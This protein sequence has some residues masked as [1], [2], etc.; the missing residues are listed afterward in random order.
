GPGMAAC[1][2]CEAEGLEIVSFSPATQE[3]INELLPP[4]ALRTNPVD[5]GPAWY[6]ASA[7]A[8]I[9]RAV[10][11]DDKVDAVLLLMMFASANREAVPG[12]A[13]LLS[14][15][16]P[17]KPLVTC[18]ISPPG[19]WDEQVEHMEDAGVLV[20]MSTPERAAK[21]LASLWHYRKILNGE[22]YER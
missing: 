13:R 12:I 16:K 1:D 19:I 8:G 5:M 18:L 6:N 14:A 7:T 2:I 21:A 20:N 4:L 3:V 17:P 10:I 15:W 11:E 9:L 22:T